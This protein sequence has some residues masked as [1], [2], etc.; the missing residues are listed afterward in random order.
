[1]RGIAGAAWVAAKRMAKSGE[2]PQSCPSPPAADGRI[3]PPTDEENSGRHGH[4][5]R[6]CHALGFRCRGNNRLRPPKVLRFENTTRKGSAPAAPAACRGIQWGT[7]AGYA[8]CAPGQH[9]RHQEIVF[10]A[11]RFALIPDRGGIDILLSRLGKDYG[12]LQGKLR[13]MRFLTASQGWAFCA[14]CS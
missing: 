8:Q 7:V 4:Q 13:S 14:S 1:M 6:D 2:W 10:Q 3:A 5:R 11:C 9:L 12:P